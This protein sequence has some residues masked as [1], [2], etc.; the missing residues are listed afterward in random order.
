MPS[1]ALI[2][3]A[4]RG[5]GFA[6]CEELL[7][8]GWAVIAGVHAKVW[9]ELEQ[10]KA[11]Y[12]LQLTLVP[13]DISSTQS[14]R[15][16]AQATGSAVS[17][18]DLLV[19]NAGILPANMHD[20]RGQQDYAEILHT[21][22][23]N[24]VG[25]LRVVEAFLPLMDQGSLKRLCFVSSDASSIARSGHTDWF[26]YCMSKSALNMATKILFNHLRRDGYTFR[27]YHPGWLRTYMR[28]KKDMKASMEADEA[29]GHALSF[30]LGDLADEDRL[31][32]V[33]Y[34]GQ[35]IPW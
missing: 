33:Y 23:V 16:A 18:I 30:F 2:T 9:P 34:H 15:A 14:V 29:A 24:A 19:N 10:L 25:A 35:V 6:L 26:G 4:G 5:L 28:G 1:T 21:F 20:I 11:R 12:S 17:G 27:L 7:K 22:D 3:G 31:E 32:L 8:R 13:M